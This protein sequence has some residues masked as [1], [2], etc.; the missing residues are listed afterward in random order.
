MAGGGASCIGERRAR[1]RCPSLVCG[2]VGHEESVERINLP[3]NSQLLYCDY[4]TFHRIIV[5]R[6]PMSGE[7][8]ED[9]QANEERDR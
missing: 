4:I 9:V 2:L 3:I 5:E 1:T 7:Q 6:V 8:E